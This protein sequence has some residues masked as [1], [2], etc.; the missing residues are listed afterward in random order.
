MRVMLGIFCCLFVLLGSYL[1]YSTVTYGEQWFSSPYNPRISASRNVA[2][3]GSIYDRNGVPLAWSEGDSRHYAENPEVREAVCHV[4][5]DV[6][7]KSMGA[8]AFY[9]RYLYGYDQ[10]LLDRFVTAFEGNEK[11]GDVY[12]TID[13]RLCEYAYS[14]M[15]FNG[16]V[17]VMDYTTGEVLASVSKP[18]FDPETLK[19]ISPEEEEGARSF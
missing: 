12:L 6:Y 15:N 14:N 16:A 13:S 18:T 10:G 4:V 17:V 8:E 11:G 1:F 7:G 3:A 2:N 19:D 9:A 5:G